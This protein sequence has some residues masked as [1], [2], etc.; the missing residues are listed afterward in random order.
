MTMVASLQDRVSHLT[1]E[2]RSAYD[3]RAA[4]H[5]DLRRMEDQL[6]YR[7]QQVAEGQRAMEERDRLMREL[8]QRR[9]EA[10]H[11]NKGGGSCTGVE[12]ARTEYCET[13]TSY[14][15]SSAS[16]GQTSGRSRTEEMH[17]APPP[18]VNHGPSES[19]RHW[20][21]RC[22]ALEAELSEWRRQG[23]AWRDAEHRSA[24]ERHALLQEVACLRAG[25]EE[26]AGLQ[27]ELNGLRARHGESLYAVGALAKLQAEERKWEAERDAMRAHVLEL[28]EELE[29]VSELLRAKGPASARAPGSV[30]IPPPAVACA[31]PG[32]SDGHALPSSRRPPLL[33]PPVATV[34]PTWAASPR[35]ASPSPRLDGG[36]GLGRCASDLVLSPRQGVH[37]GVGLGR[38]ASVA[39]LSPP[40]WAS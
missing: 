15:G 4:L 5:D 19:E 9:Q 29:R 6:H 23:N 18:S 32:P 14:S 1:V 31:S 16:P 21:Q 28:T 7:D 17:F 26:M 39:G 20:Q 12:S 40:A 8:T 36:G 38:C 22:A 37:R 25:R 33:R 34:A 10:A 27:L 13:S 35:Q 3:E 30:P 11:W 24:C 2:L